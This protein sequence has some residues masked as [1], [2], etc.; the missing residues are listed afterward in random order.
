VEGGQ[1]RKEQGIIGG[2]PYKVIT[3][4]AIFDFEPN[5]K[6]MRL[7]GV[8]TGMSLEKVLENMEFKPLVKESIIEIPPPT[9]EEL[10]ILRSLD[11]QRVFIK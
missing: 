5:T 2:G 1:S 10:Q 9:N 11:P 6:M 4:K 7:E 8:L 3:D